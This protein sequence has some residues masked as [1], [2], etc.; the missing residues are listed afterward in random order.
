MQSVVVSRLRRHRHVGVLLLAAH[1]HLHGQIIAKSSLC[2]SET[3]RTLHNTRCAQLGR[4]FLVDDGLAERHVGGLLQVLVLGEAHLA[5]LSTV[6][7]N[8]V[9]VLENIAAS[10]FCPQIVHLNLSFLKFQNFKSKRL[11]LPA[12]CTLPNRWSTTPIPPLNNF[13]SF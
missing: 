12:T 11:Y 10:C 3:L 9:Q 13:K 7:V 8:L 4:F 2:L 5:D 6:A 1:L